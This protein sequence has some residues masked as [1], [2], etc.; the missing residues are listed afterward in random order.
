MPMRKAS[1][2]NSLLLVISI[3]KIHNFKSGLNFVIRSFRE[4]MFWGLSV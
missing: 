3:G 1:P 2:L 4:F